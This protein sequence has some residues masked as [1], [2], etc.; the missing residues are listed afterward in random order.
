MHNSTMT[1]FQRSE[2]IRILRVFHNIE[3]LAVLTD[4][5]LHGLWLDDCEYENPYK[6][7]EE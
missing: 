5:E 4:T 7:D 1:S 6:K 3:E 2:L